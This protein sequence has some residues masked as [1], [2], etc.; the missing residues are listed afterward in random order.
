MSFFSDVIIEFCQFPRRNRLAGKHSHAPR[1]KLDRP[2]L[3]VPNYT[4]QGKPWVILILQYFKY[5]WCSTA[6]RA[7]I[8]IVRLWKGLHSFLKCRGTLLDVTVIRTE[9]LFGKVHNSI[10]CQELSN[11]FPFLGCPKPFPLLGGWNLS[12]WCASTNASDRKCTSIQ[13]AMPK[14]ATALVHFALEQSEYMQYICNYIRTKYIQVP[15]KS[16]QVADP[17]LFDKPVVFTTK[18]FAI[19]D[20]LTTLNAMN[21]LLSCHCENTV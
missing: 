20:G 2:K 16:H 15:R 21:I 4:P 14:E 3:K 19:V 13:N 12:L 5:V 17:K 10:A 1:P 11:Q 7:T 6:G 9:C 18:V 8:E